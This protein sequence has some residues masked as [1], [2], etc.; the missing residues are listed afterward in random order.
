MWVS[1][2]WVRGSGFRVS[3]FGFRSKGLRLGFSGFE[4]QAR[5]SYFGF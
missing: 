2:C 5:C 1:C 3:G 4:L